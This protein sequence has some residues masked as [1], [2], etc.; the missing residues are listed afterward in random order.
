[1]NK[2]NTKQNKNKSETKKKNTNKGKKKNIGPVYYWTD[3]TNH[4]NEYC[5]TENCFYYWRNREKK[6]GDYPDVK[7]CDDIDMCFRDAIWDQHFTRRYDQY[8]TYDSKYYDEYIISLYKKFFK[9]NYYKPT[10][11]WPD[12]KR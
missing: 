10:P 4:N 3:R 11:I 7:L 12:K 6:L 9:I 5:A 1:M 2:K 8:I